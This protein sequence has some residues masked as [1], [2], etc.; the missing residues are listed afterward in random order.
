V[1]ANVLTYQNLGVALSPSRA[2]SKERHPGISGHD[3]TKPLRSRC[4]SSLASTSG[5]LAVVKLLRS[6]LVPPARLSGLYMGEVLS[7]GA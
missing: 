7:A 3:E 6:A 1:D 4:D 5:V 2:N